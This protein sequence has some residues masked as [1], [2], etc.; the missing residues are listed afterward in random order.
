[1]RLIVFLWIVF[2]TLVFADFARA[3]GGGPLLLLFNL[4]VFIVGQIWIISIEF[5]IY[6]RMIK[7]SKEDAFWDVVTANIYSTIV[8]AFGIPVFIAALGIAGNFIPGELGAIWTAISTWIYDK[9]KYGK[10]SVYA[11]LL[12]FFILFVLTVYFEAWIFIKRWRKREFSAEVK[13]IKL[14]WYS[15]AISHF[16]LFIA[17]LII[18]RELM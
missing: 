17:I 16:G 14:C 5:L 11:S 6:R 18:W 2:V 8:V 9:A 15:N 1:M 4:S 7:T 12:W 13:P 3:S 10:L